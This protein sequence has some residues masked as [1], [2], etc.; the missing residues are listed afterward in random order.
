MLYEIFH[1]TPRKYHESRVTFTRSSNSH[2][3]I[4]FL[5]F[6]KSPYTFVKNFSKTELDKKFSKFP[7]FDS[8]SL[9][10]FLQFFFPPSFVF[11]NLQNRIGRQKN[12]LNF[13]FNSLS[14]SLSLSNSSFVFQNL[15]NRHW[16]AKKFSKFPIQ[17]TLSLFLSNPSSLEKKSSNPFETFTPTK[18]TCRTS[19]WRI[20]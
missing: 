16:K 13:Q 10:L 5:I 1:Q 17:F 3:K 11:Q 15:Q 9:S 18:K 14:L 6:P 12:S 2:T 7:W 20:T 19:D 8:F 4:F